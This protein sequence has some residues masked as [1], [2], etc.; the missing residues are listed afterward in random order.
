VRTRLRKWEVVTLVMSLILFVCIGSS[1][2]FY[3]YLSEDQIKEAIHYGKDNK[4]TGLT[5]FK[6]WEVDFGW[7]IG[8]AHLYSP[9]F[10]LAFCAQEATRE[11]R[12]VTDYE[13]EVALTGQGHLTFDLLLWG[14][15][16]TFGKDY[17]AV[18]LYEGKYIQPFFKK[19]DELA[20]WDETVSKYE[21][22]FIYDFSLVSTVDGEKI[23]IDTNGK[24]T[25]III[26]WVGKETRFEFDLSKIR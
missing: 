19:N 13:K 6:E 12:S 24:V 7:G 1:E 2:A 9:F 18:L 26:P 20:K 25:L 3:P 8:I 5:F 10:L 15:S 23:S 17:H 22:H 4:D 16:I 11:Y 21:G 14:D